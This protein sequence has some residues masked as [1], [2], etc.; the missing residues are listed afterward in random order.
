[1]S[2]LRTKATLKGEAHRAAPA[3]V[4]RRS[5]DLAANQSSF[6]LVFVVEKNTGGIYHSLFCGEDENHLISFADSFYLLVKSLFNDILATSLLRDNSSLRKEMSDLDSSLR[7]EM[8]DLDSSL[9]KEMSDLDSSLRKEI[10]DLDSSLRKEKTD[11]NRTISDLVLKEKVFRGLSNYYSSINDNC[12]SA[13]SDKISSLPSSLAISSS[14]SSSSPLA[15]L[16]VDVFCSGTLEYGQASNALAH[17]L[18]SRDLSSSMSAEVVYRFN[19][20][21]GPSDNQLDSSPSSSSSSSS[22]STWVGSLSR[23]TCRPVQVV[24]Q[25]LDSLLMY[26]SVSHY[27]GKVVT[28]D[29]NSTSGGN[30]HMLRHPSVESISASTVGIAIIPLSAAQNEGSIYGAT[31]VSSSSFNLDKSLMSIVLLFDDATKWNDFQYNFFKNSSENQFPSLITSLISGVEGRMALA[32][33]LASMSSDWAKSHDVVD[34]F[35]KI[36]SS[37]LEW[38][39][40]IAA[41][42]VDT[43]GSDSVDFIET[44]IRDVVTNIAAAFSRLQFSPGDGTSSSASGESA[45]ITDARLFWSCKSSR[46]ATYLRQVQHDYEWLAL[47]PTDISLQGPSATRPVPLNSVVKTTL[48]NILLDILFVDKNYGYFIDFEKSSLWM[49][50]EIHNSSNNVGSDYSF[51]FQFA[52]SNFDELFADFRAGSTSNMASDTCAVRIESGLKVVVTKCINDLK[53]MVSIILYSNFKTYSSLLYTQQLTSIISQNNS[54]LKI[55]SDIVSDLSSDKPLSSKSPD[56]EKEKK[57]KEKES[58]KLFR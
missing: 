24:H 41:I 51:L 30:L 34:L 46:G 28:I 57:K 7:K 25:P 53:Q 52:I 11:F 43:T 10:S 18:T 9:R 1:V 8:S 19:V 3:L 22:S 23:I 55:L 27:Y 13:N 16:L 42:S 29:P 4:V 39:S 49:M 45:T 36:C 26:I 58:L 44:K 47:A 5:I 35:D 2:I 31:P 17:R 6:E 15:Q 20:S 38:N 40:S 50:V 12:A 32:S 14:S 37:M 33:S 56:K 21:H 54:K 48:S